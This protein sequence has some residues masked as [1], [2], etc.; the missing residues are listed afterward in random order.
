MAEISDKQMAE[1]FL[2]ALLAAKMAK[3]NNLVENGHTPQP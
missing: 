1:F 2:P 3:I